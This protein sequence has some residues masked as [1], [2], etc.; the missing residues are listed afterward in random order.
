PAVPSWHERYLGADVGALGSLTVNDGR[1]GYAETPERPTDERPPGDPTL[2]AAATLTTL[3]EQRGVAVGG[4]P[5]VGVAPPGAAAVAAH[6]SP[7]VAELTREL[8]AH[9]DNESAEVLVRELGLWGGGA[10][11]TEAGLAQVVAALTAQAVPLEGAVLVDGSGLD[12]ANRVTCTTLAAVLEANEDVPAFAGGLAVAGTSGTL[13]SRFVDSSV[14]G[15][16]R[17]KTGSLN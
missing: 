10:G 12:T 16:L 9:S 5:T 8:L 4:P 11:S 7:T 3:L 17:A 6:P 13:R 15:R 1:E 14:T 2:L